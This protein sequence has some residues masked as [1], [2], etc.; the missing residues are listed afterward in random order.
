MCD[1]IC[2]PCDIE[3]VGEG[4]PEQLICGFDDEEKI[5]DEDTEENIDS[6]SAR[7]AIVDLGCEILWTIARH[8]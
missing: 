8:S 4:R 5:E 3:N 2:L 1:N 6:K 7:F